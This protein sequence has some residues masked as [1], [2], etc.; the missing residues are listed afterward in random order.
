MLSSLIP[1]EDWLT[2]HWRAAAHVTRSVSSPCPSL[3]LGAG[4]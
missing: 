1:R 2:G 4:E 3:V